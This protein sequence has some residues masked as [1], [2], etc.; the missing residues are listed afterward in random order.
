[1]MVTPYIKRGWF[2][3]LSNPR[4][5]LYIVM[6]PHQPAVDLERAEELDVKVLRVHDTGP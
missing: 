4:R 5:F 3:V 2:F 1:M 6:D